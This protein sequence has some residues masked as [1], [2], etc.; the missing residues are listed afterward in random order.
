MRPKSI[1]WQLP[2]SYGAIALLSS[3]ALGIVLL[4]VMRSYYLQRELS[5]LESNANAINAEIAAMLAGNTP[6][7]VLESQIASY[8]FLSQ[9]RIRVFAAAGNT[10]ADSGIPE[11]RNLLSISTQQTVRQT[12]DPELERFLPEEDII[13]LET[14]RASIEMPVGINVGDDTVPVYYT[15]VINLDFVRIYPDQEAGNV[16]P[17][18]QNSRSDPF[19]QS[20][21]ATGT[22]YGFGLSDEVA[23]NAGRSSQSVEQTLYDADGEPLGAIL[24]SHGP[25]YGRQIV[26]RVA[27]GL[28]IASLLAIVVGVGAGWF[29]S[30]SITAPLT[31]LEDIT[32]RMAD[33]DLSVRA[34]IDRS[35]ELGALARTF[36]HMARQIENTVVTLRRFIADAAHELHTPLTA[37][38]TNLELA[39]D[40]TSPTAHQNYLDRARRQAL[41]LQT[42]A[43][44]LLDLS[45]LESGMPDPYKPVLLNKLVQEISELYAS[46]SEYEKI[47]FLL[48]ITDEPIAVFGNERQIRSALGNLLDNAIK[49][50]PTG[51]TVSLCMKRRGEQVEIVVQDRGI[52]IPQDELT[53]IF[54]RFHRCRNAVTYTGSGLGLAIVK[55]VI[56]FHRGEVMVRNTFP[57][58]CFTIR[59]PVHT[60]PHPWPAALPYRAVV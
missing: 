40:E 6:R 38:R 35:D 58:V 33:G 24:F 57:G 55:R 18:S 39:I 14:F 42:L 7:P 22:L 49:F 28:L 43:D 36:N 4:M 10:V 60:G 25:A 19:S 26:E 9:V 17:D 46:R 53:Y 50:T 51:E 32:T 30:R 56:D 15:P 52:G 48:E 27:Y 13:D 5:Y 21:S 47:Q 31:K 3:L 41:R 29:I 8:A 12:V 2:F 37:L 59:L 11:G 20:L 34:E 54:S 45:R 16:P 44:G 23:P 1:R